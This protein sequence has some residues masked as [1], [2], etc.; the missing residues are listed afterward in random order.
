MQVGPGY[1]SVNRRF[2]VV[3]DEVGDT[4]V[5]QLGQV[6]DGDLPGAAIERPYIRTRRR[7]NLEEFPA[8]IKVNV[9]RAG[10]GACRGE[11]DAKERANRPTDWTLRVH[12][13]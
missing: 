2:D 4:L 7:L 8:D 9:G 1:Q 12:V 3:H 10:H 13:F 6:E 11:A 5:Q